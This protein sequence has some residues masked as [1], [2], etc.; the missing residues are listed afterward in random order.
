MFR[1]DWGPETSAGRQQEE[2][3]QEGSD[4]EGRRL[5]LLF[6]PQVLLAGTR[7]LWPHRVDTIHFLDNDLG[8]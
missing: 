4:G 8:P 3:A 6:P 1:A 2:A 7:S 5:G